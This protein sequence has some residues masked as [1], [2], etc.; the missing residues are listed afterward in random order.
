MS[1]TTTALSPTA[2]AEAIAR[3]EAEELDILVIG[4]GVVGAGTALD[5]VTRGL[6]VG[7]LEAR[8]YAAGTSSRS[9]KLFHG[10]LRYLEQFNFSLV[11]EALKE[12][13]LVLNT[14]CP[15]LA[16]PV[17]FIYPLEKVIDRPYVGLGIGVYDVMGAGRGVPSHHKHLGKKKTLE[18]FP[19]GKRSAIRGAVKFY[20]G[21]V[22]DA[23]HTMMIARTAAAYGALCANS[24]RVTG[25]LREDDKVVGVVASDLETGRSFEV[26]AKQ[27]INAAGVWTDEVQQMVGGRGQFQVRASKGVHLVVPRNRIN[28]ATGIIT[29][30]EKSLLF[31]IPWGS[32]WIIGTTDTDWKLDL[33]HPAASQS[34]IDYI[35]GHVNKLLADPLDRADVVGVYAGLRPLLFGE[36]DSTSTLSR[37]HAVSSPVRGLTVIAGGKYTTYRVMAKD[38]VD[39]AVHGLERTVPKCVTENIP[40]VGADGYLGAYNS[41]NLTAER[42][43]MRVSRVEHLLGRYGTL[44][45][46]VLDLID[47]DPELGKPLDSAP[48]YLKAEVVYAASHEGAQHLE[49]ILTRRTR[50]SIE[51]PDRG[52][53]AAEEVARLVAP[54]LGWDDQ[55]RTEE[56]EHYRLR[57]L[58]E[59]DS[60]QQPDDETA[61]AARL[62]APDVRA[63]V[64]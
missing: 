44:M 22:D 52:E 10:G 9:S 60:Q 54:I 48:E 53:A 4:G 16:R 1:S 18:S 56:I 59:R 64:S 57:V 20:E 2:R 41:R 15:H 32:H 40:L 45:G 51:V 25:F 39:A 62:G 37:E 29:R 35:L 17:P 28:S 21:Q 30:T 26:R 33:A 49:D 24:T 50:I 23:R 7:L 27:V 8:D 58:A 19:S 14:L 6:K 3:M 11:F 46:E 36:S 55:H 61:D 38:A 12:R 34:D 13:S 63:G 5:A 31:V 42:T 43:G 47:A